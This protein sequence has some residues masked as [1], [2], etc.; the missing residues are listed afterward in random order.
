MRAL[1]FCTDVVIYLACN[2]A[3]A[4]SAS[5]IWPS[6]S[7]FSSAAGPRRAPRTSTSSAWFRSR[8]TR[9]STPAARHAGLDRLLVNVLAESLQPALFLHF[10]LSFPEERLKN[11][12][13]A[14]C[15]PLVYAP[16]AACSACGS[17]PSEL[18]QATGFC[19]STAGP[20]APPTTPFLRAGRLLFPA[21]LQ[22]RQ[23]AAAAPAVEVAH[24]RHA[25]GGLP[26]TLFY[27]I[28]FSSTCIRPAAHQSGRPVAGLF[29]A[30]LQ[31]GHRPLPADGH[32]PDLQA[33]RGL[34]AGHRPD[35]RRLLRH[36]RA[37]RRWRTTPA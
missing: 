27:A 21:Q 10:A 13:A 11:S 34:H 9:S 35:A 18:R 31:L 4:S 30:H 20:D 24:P 37:G 16:G 8:S 29:A 19:S 5:S 15:L 3:C 12:A 2:W 33:R 1:V 22:P 23:H 25:A 28:P 36:H 17:G 7:T 26:F 6:A 14:G 32:R